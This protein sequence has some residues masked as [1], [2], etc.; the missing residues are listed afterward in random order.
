VTAALLLRMT[1]ELESLYADELVS[2]QL[3]RRV[4]RTPVGKMPTVV[5]TIA[6]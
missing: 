1:Q 4:M 6:A 2:D 3:L 5:K